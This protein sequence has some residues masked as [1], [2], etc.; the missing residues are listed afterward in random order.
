MG[1]E[2]SRGC[3]ATWQNGQFSI[4]TSEITFPA[5]LFVSN[6]FETFERAYDDRVLILSC[7]IYGNK[8]VTARSKFE[9][10]VYE[11]FKGPDLVAFYFKELNFLM[12]LDYV[13]STYAIVDGNVYYKRDFTSVYAGARLDL[14]VAYS[15]GSIEVLTSR[16]VRERNNSFY[17]NLNIPLLN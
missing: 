13:A 11:I 4:F 6:L 7:D 10:P 16:L 3:P 17:I 1:R 9:M 8:I 15:G 12:G 2:T 14:D 5:D